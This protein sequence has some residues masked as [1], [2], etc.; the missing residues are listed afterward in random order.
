MQRVISL[1]PQQLQPNL[2]CGAQYAEMPPKCQTVWLHTPVWSE[3]SKYGGLV[4]LPYATESFHSHD[5]YQMKYSAS[6]AL[7]KTPRRLVRIAQWRDL[8][9]IFVSLQLTDEGKAARAKMSVGDVILSINGISTDGTN[10]LE[11]QNKIKACTGNLSL[12]LQR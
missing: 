2:W 12:T 9:C 7:V 5:R 10:H 6:S 8:L 11:A 4:P 3:K 1:L